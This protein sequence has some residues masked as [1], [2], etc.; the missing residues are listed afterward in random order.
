VRRREA[1]VCAGAL[2]VVFLLAGLSGPTRR[3]AGALAADGRPSRFYEWKS[4]APRAPGKLLRQEQLPATLHLAG[5]RVNRRILYSSTGWDDR[6]IVVSGAYFVP[7]GRPPKG[8]W[9]VLAWAHGTVGIAD[10]C[11]PSWS[12]QS[13]RDLTYLTSWLAEGYAIVATDYA[14]L[15][16]QG[17]HPYNNIVSEARSVIDA[18]R[19]VARKRP[20]FSRRWA[21]MGQSQGGGAALGTGAIESEY[22]RDRLTF[23]GVL[24][25][26][27]AARDAVLLTRFRGDRPNESL[28]YVPLMLRSLETVD[29]DFDAM[30][31]VTDRGHELLTRADTDCFYEIADWVTSSG[32]TGAVAL[33]E[34]APDLVP[35]GKKYFDPPASGYDKPVLVAQGDADTTVLPGL[36]DALA[37]DMC[38]SGTNLLYLKYPGGTHSSTML[39]SRAD[40]V[41]WVRAL[42]AGN[43]PPG[44][45]DAS[46]TIAAH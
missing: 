40:T 10:R 16:T 34:T 1:R 35:L 14:G 39:D 23:L 28:A 27:P 9:P 15:G 18:V 46:I 19:A 6:P 42:F 26:G 4:R 20:D 11:A 29:P 45:C 13:T 33:P 37:R 38:A 24:A 21:V 41:P 25:T 17:T 5:A 44:N 43:P 22:G 32:L 8:G 3:E 12:G 2:A 31:Y 36:T 30:A 7:E